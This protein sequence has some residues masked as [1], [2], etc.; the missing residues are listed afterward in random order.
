LLD[1]GLV[2]FLR[3]VQRLLASDAELRQ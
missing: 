3:A 1:Q 2:A